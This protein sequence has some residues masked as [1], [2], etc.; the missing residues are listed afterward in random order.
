ME[1]NRVVNLVNFV[2][3]CEPRPEAAGWHLSQ[4]TALL[5]TRG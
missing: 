5:P 3:G 1:K 4:V 2:R